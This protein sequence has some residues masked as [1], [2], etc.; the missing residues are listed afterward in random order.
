[1]NILQSLDDISLRKKTLF[2]IGITLVILT[3]LMY[4]ISSAIL[5]GGFAEVEKHDTDQNV[6]R[7]TEALWADLS[8]LSGVAGDFAAWDD[9]YSFIEDSDPA[10]IESNV[11]DTTFIGFNINFWFYINSSGGIVWEKNFDLINE[12]EIPVPDSLY[13]HL[14]VNSVLF[15]HSSPESNIMGLVQLP[16]GPVLVVSRPILDNERIKPIRGSMIWGYYLN[17]E[18]IK[19]LSEITHLSLSIKPYDTMQL[20]PDFQSARNSIS[21]EEPIFIQQLNEQ[22]VAGY[23]ILKDIYGDPALLL[24]VDLPRAIYNQGRVSVNYLL[25]SLIIVGIIFI[26]ISAILLEKLILSRVA[27]LNADVDSIGANG[28]LSK[29]VIMR[30]NDELSKLAGSIN[31]MLE[32]LEHAELERK[33]AEEIQLENERLS[34]A[35]RAKSEFLATMSHELRTPLNGILGFS[36]ILI[37]KIAGDLNAKQE[38]YVE[39]INSSGNHLLRIINDILLLTQIEAGKLELASEKI[40]VAEAINDVE[41]L[42]KDKSKEYNI[43]FKED[44]DQKIEFIEAD[45]IKFKQIMFNLLGNAVKFSKEKGGTITIATKRIGDLAQFSVSDTGIGIKEEDRG[46]LFKKFQQVDSGINRDYGGTGLGLAISKQLVELHGGKIWVESKYGEWT[47]FYFTLPII[48]IR[49]S[50]I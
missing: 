6:Q 41:A 1:M 2:I 3:V 18:Q 9:S 15:Q 42:F 30:G 23:T 10:F 47:T 16:E 36:E 13:K 50:E 25:V 48:S 49:R 22:S 45:P 29:R 12:T 20:S 40:K 21:E 4:V 39:N 5:M 26:G 38:R 34:Y 44:L 35:N 14:S 31:G 17:D 7:A 27:N 46:K 19:R 32:L 24:R 33:K 28:K 43:G 11:I 37:N 8:S